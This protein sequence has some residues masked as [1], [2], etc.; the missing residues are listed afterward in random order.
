M[1]EVTSDRLQIAYK[2]PALENGQMSM[3]ALGSSLRGQAILIQR[4]KDMLYGDLFAISV[5]LDYQ[6]EPWLLNS[7]YPHPQRCRSSG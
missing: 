4:V 3:L 1:Q 7:T 2:G 5:E 6:F